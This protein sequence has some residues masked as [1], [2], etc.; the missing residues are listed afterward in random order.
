MVTVCMASFNGENF[1]REQ[2][3]SILKQLSTNDELIISDDS[4]YD[5]T[6]EIIESIE[7]NRI[8]LLKNQRFKNHIFNFENALKHAKG[9]IIF[10]SDQDDVWLPNKVDI[11]KFYFEQTKSNLIVS[12]CIVVDHNLKEIRNSFYHYTRKSGHGLIKNFVRNSYLGCC[13]A[14]NRTVVEAAIPF[15]KDL[16]SHDTWLGLTAELLG[17]TKFIEEKLL[18]FRRHGSNFSTHGNSTSGDTVLTKKSKYSIFQILWHRIIL[19]KNLFY[20]Y[21]CLKIDI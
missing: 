2:I 13:M 1:I 16:K 9:D 5:N 12:D 11:F 8:K 7:D 17:E 10:L 4:S 15:P 6:I 19:F 18:L 14:F 20:R 3:Y 21:I